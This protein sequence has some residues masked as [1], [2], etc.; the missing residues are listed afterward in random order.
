[1]SEIQEKTTC[2]LKL[3]MP[4][5]IINNIYSELFKNIEIAGVINCDKNNNIINVK[6]NTGSSDSVYTPNHVINFHTHPISAYNAANTVWGWPSG[7]D[8]RETI[9]FA[10]NGNKAHLV[11]TVE[12]LYTI[13]INPC[14]IA[15]IKK[16]NSIE[17]G[18]LIFLIEEYF[19]TTHNFR[20]TEE[21][22]D[23]NSNK[24][25]ITPYSYIDFV[26][27]FQLSNLLSSKISIHKKSK[28]NNSSSLLE[29]QII[30]ENYSR[31]PNIGFPTID[32]TDIVNLPFKDYIS[33][34]EL[35][36]LRSIDNDGIE[37]KS[38]IKNINDIKKYMDNIFHTF[39]SKECK[40]TWNN[41]PNLWFHVNFFPSNNYINKNYLNLDKFIVPTEIKLLKLEKQ[42]FIH[43]FSNKNNGCTIHEICKINNFNLSDSIKIKNN[44]SSFGEAILSFEQRTELYKILMD[45]IKLKQILSIPEI[46]S[47]MTIP[48]TKKQIKLELLLLNKFI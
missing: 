1:M 40:N 33:P 44:K 24:I 11:F 5:N 28:I 42:P 2:K 22:N 29:N 17:R 12:G 21:V 41:K 20:G 36:E 46:I 31:I 32:S 47:K 39:K 18:I 43:I 8:I 37:S 14:K 23:L 6:K 7:E 19:K 30:S 3:Y 35:K 9:K 38:L 26:N 16:L 4:L 10:L 45:S 25:K 48:A 15:K 34:S 27:T 13:Q